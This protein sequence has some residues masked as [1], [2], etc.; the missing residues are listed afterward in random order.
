MLTLPAARRTD[1]GFV[2]IGYA[3]ITPDGGDAMLDPRWQPADVALAGDVATVTPATG[4][5]QYQVWYWPQVTVF[6]TRPQVEWVGQ[7]A[8]SGHSYSWSLEAREV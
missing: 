2:P 7:P 8:G 4:A 1:A 6:A 3:L 5:L